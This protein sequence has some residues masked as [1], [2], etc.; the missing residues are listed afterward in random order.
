MKMICKI[1]PD[2]QS[3][4]TCCL[5]RTF[6]ELQ[7]SGFRLVDNVAD[8]IDIED[9]NVS[10]CFACGLNKHGLIC[11]Q[12]LPG[13]EILAHAQRDELTGVQCLSQVQGQRS[14]DMGLHDE[15]DMPS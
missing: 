13:F 6:H 14:I 1:L 5:T 2:C 3:S 12:R 11:F 15:M 8:C 10:T 9:I 7:D 4:A